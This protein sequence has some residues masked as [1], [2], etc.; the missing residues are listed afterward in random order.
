MS[1][2]DLF[3]FCPRCGASLKQPPK[4]PTI[5]CPACDFLFYFNPTISVAAFAE[6]PDGKVIFI[7]RAHDPGKGKLAIPGGFV[8]IGETA[9]NALLREFREEV[10]IELA[11]LHY[12]TSEANYYPYRGVT[13]PVL[14]LYYVARVRDAI[15]AAALDGVESYGWFDPAEVA[16]EEIAFASMRAALALFV[17]KRRAAR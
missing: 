13:Y 16:P 17:D 10:N 9:E 8:D 14:D 7:R 15:K 11:G 5:H 2:I 12:L 6:G 1:P 4:P 3:K